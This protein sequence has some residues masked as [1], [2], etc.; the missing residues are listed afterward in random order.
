MKKRM[1]FP[2]MIALT[3]MFLLTGC[4]K[5]DDNNIVSDPDPK[6]VAQ[7]ALSSSDFSMLVYA[8]DKT[9]LIQ[10]LNSPGNFTVF[11]PKNSAFNTLLSDLGLESLD[12]LSD[13]TL[14]NV[15]LYHVLGTR[16]SSGMLTSGY[17]KSLSPAQG[18]TLSMKIDV[19]S[20]VKIN[21]SVNVVSADIQATNGVVHVIDR[22]M[23][24]PTIVDIAA[25]N[26]AFSILVEAVVKADLAGTLSGDGPFTVFAP[27]NDAFEALFSTLGVNGIADLSAETLAPIL[28]YHVVGG[29]VTSADLEEGQVPTLNGGI[30]VKLSPSPAINGDSKIVLTDVQ[31]TNGIIHVI[32]KVLL[33]AKK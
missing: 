33:P 17:Y 26:P 30:D 10:V 20:S 5:D 18:N 22:V 19:G 29:N 1:I 31:G 4:E 15:L 13:E 21:N 27:T 6:T 32:D 8:L 25:A 28:L 2:V 12:K 24:P 3:G 16:I 23:L 14:T 11:A 7:V 9:G